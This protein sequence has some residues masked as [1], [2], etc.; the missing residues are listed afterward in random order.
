MTG[1]NARSPAPTVDSRN[2][3]FVDHLVDLGVP[4]WA[5]EFYKGGWHRPSGWQ[6]LTAGGSRE[7]LARR[8]DGAPI[9]ANLGGPVAV[10][11]VDVKN[12]ADVTKIETALDGIG[13]TIYA[14]VITP[15][16]GRH[17]Y[18]PGHLELPTVRATADRDG[19]VG[20]PGV[21]ILSYGSNVFLPGS[22][23]AE[24]DGVPYGIIFDDLAKL[25]DGG[26][27]ASGEALAGWVA[28]HR[29]V[30]PEPFDVSPPWDG[31][32]PDSRQQAYLDRV[33]RN[34]ADRIAAMGP[35]SGRNTA[36]YNA[37]LVLG[38]FAAGAGLKPEE[39][40]EQIVA[41]A[42]VCG[43]V[44][45]DGERSVRA[46]IASGMRNGYKRPRQV[47]AEEKLTFNGGQAVDPEPP[48]DHEFWR[49]R[50][51]LAHI[52]QFARAR[53]V[54]PW[55]VLGTVL[56]RTIALTPWTIALPPIVGGRA[57]LNI[58]IATVAR[59]GGGKGAADRA[60]RDAI[61]W[62]PVHEYKIASGEA[63]A[64]CLKR[65]VPDKQGGGAEWLHTDRS[66]L[67]FM[68]E[69]D[70]V[71]AQAARPGATI[72]SEL[73]SGWSGEPLGHVTADPARRIPV[74]A[75][76]YRLALSIGVQPL[77]AGAI[78]D[79]ADGGFPQRLVWVSAI[80]PQAPDR[81]PELPAPMPWT[82]PDPGLR[83]DDLIDVCAGAAV[84]IINARQDGL[85]GKGD[86]LD[87]QKLLAR[88][89][90]AAALGILDG[91]YS[92]TDE[93]WQLAGIV[94][95]HSD[96]VRDQV[97]HE[98]ANKSAEIEQVRTRAAA[99]RAAATAEAVIEATVQRVAKNMLRHVRDAG[100]IPYHQLLKKIAAR[101][102][103]YLEEALDRLRAAGLVT[104]E[105]RPDNRAEDGTARIIKAIP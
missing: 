101:D 6:H 50:P 30:T 89:K 67:V 12:G 95:E 79:D 59:S 9:C 35:N 75:D 5:Q 68:P 92:I 61:R 34:Q 93:D 58:A 74:E 15:S 41:A 7:R 103:D 55:A 33:V 10:V 36:C 49:A 69:V 99:T 104:V 19:L 27:E 64:H 29:R 21:E 98:L 44:A 57:S 28:T 1:S 25:A 53:L 77:R 38:N 46:S 13:V 90:V 96:H 37:G 23:R 71:T 52:E 54:A 20:H 100:E 66:A 16:G 8:P 65:R 11:D 78:L 26:D 81:L 97:R 51:V 60:A 88:E 4:I 82:P 14:D 22:R 42:T 56:A 39:S 48:D 2:D 87:G 17:F 45:D 70:K 105:Q 94:I 85:R 62:P 72:M 91:R 86:P 73:R 102:R 80:D 40:T 47:P 63:I 24:Y 76:A 83:T 43:L 31:T 84:Q 18:V 32:E 3:E